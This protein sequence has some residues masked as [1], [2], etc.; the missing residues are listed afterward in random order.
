MNTMSNFGFKSQLKGLDLHDSVKEEDNEMSEELTSH[1]TGDNHS[2]P[3]TRQVVRDNN[4]KI[5][6]SS[7]KSD[8]EGD[9]II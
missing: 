4:M 8:L 2:Q 9:V 5:E 3:V 1:H 6:E 7:R